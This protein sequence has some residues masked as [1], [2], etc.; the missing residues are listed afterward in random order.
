MFMRHSLRIVYGLGHT[1]QFLTH[2]VMEKIR[3]KLCAFVSQWRI[4]LP[5]L[6]LT[7]AA[8]FKGDGPGK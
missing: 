3:G 5:I 1:A 7:G 2:G 6:H 4:T 8:L